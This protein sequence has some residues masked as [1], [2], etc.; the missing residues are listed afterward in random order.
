MR[1]YFMP[2]TTGQAPPMTEGEALSFG[3][4]AAVPII[5]FVLFIAVVLIGFR[6]IAEIGR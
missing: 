5:G 2:Y 1:T 3:W 4:E 6:L